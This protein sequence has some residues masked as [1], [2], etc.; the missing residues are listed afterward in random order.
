MTFSFFLSIYSRCGAPASWA[1]RHTI[2]CL[3]LTLDLSVL[4]KFAA[5]VAI[6]KI[7]QYNQHTVI[8]TALKFHTLNKIIYNAQGLLKYLRWF[9]H[10][11]L[12]CLSLLSAA[13]QLTYM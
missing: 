4:V 8:V 12:L 6:Y 7:Q 13:I 1:A 10:F 11:F 5:E 2:V 3:D 9:S